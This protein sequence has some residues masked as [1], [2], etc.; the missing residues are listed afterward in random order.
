MRSPL[1]KAL[2]ACVLVEL[3]LP[4]LFGAV[5]HALLGALICAVAFGGPGSV[6]LA[7]ALHR[8]W[9]PPPRP[10][11]SRARALS[12]RPARKPA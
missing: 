6:W 7:P 11:A 2:L 4:G 12:G 5:T 8:R 3:T 10:A 9:R 1:P